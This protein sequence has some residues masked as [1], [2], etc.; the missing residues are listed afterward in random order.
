MGKGP[1]AF[2]FEDGCKWEYQMFQQKQQ[3]LSQCSKDTKRWCF[4][5]IRVAADIRNFVIIT[6]KL[7]KISLSK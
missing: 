6:N 7:D 4:V 5:D 3:K 2:I 1:L